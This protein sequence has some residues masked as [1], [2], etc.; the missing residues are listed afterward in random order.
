M[1]KARRRSVSPAS[2]RIISPA[3]VVRG[4]FQRGVFVI[5]KTFSKAYCALLCPFAH[6]DRRTQYRQ[7]NLSSRN[8]SNI[9]ITKADRQHRSSCISQF[10]YQAP[11][12]SS[13]QNVQICA[14]FCEFWF[15]FRGV[16][17]GKELFEK[18]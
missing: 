1:N 18:T 4:T 7:A 9:S 6:S 15:S 12:P 10:S 11:V 2:L 13:T 16:L 5:P 14:L 8:F 17:C 3:G